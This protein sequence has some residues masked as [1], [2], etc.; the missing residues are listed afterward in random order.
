LLAATWVSSAGDGIRVV[1]L[2]LLA[3]SIAA[4]PLSVAFVAAAQGLPWLLFTLPA[5]AF[6]DRWDRRRVL[7]TANLV[8]AGLLAALAISVAAH[9]ISIVTLCLVAFVLTTAETLADSAAPA[10]LPGLVDEADLEKA[11]ARLSIAYI[12]TNQFAG[13]PLGS[14]LFAVQRAIPF[15]LDAFSFAGAAWLIGTVKGSRSRASSDRRTKGLP[16]EIAEGL[17]WLRNHRV[18]RALA[19]LLMFSSVL[20]ETL[21]AVFVL[22]ARQVLHVPAAGYGLLFAVYAVGGLA[23]S[24]V[25]ARLRNRI[26]DGPAILASVV[27]F[28]LPMIGLRLLRDYW[29][30]GLLMGV[31]GAAEGT[32]TVL[33]VSLRQALI[34]DQLLGRVLSAFRLI[35]WGGLALG[36]LGGGLLADMFGLRAVAL[37][38]GTVITVSA[39]FGVPVLN[40]EAIQRARALAENPQPDPAPL[41]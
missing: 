9:R 23:G 4:D 35:G 7:V 36:A 1:A 13:P 28:G 29:I 18:L 24:A 19:V 34:P 40:T 10:L 30:A 15:T 20:S 16:T 22:F 32:W 37:V 31:M 12:T 21:F 8:R 17:R 5:G 2:P 27:F 38:A 25:A 3:A 33:T 14:A 26:G 6:V 39:V 11:N 41:D